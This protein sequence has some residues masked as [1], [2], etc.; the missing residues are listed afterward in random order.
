MVHQG[1]QIRLQ[2]GRQIESRIR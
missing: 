1:Q 2:R